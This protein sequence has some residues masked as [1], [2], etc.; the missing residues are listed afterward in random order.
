MARTGHILTNFLIVKGWKYP[1][2][3]KRL[4]DWSYKPKATSIVSLKDVAKS[5][6]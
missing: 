2:L 1:I 6:S 5:K 3:G 4:K